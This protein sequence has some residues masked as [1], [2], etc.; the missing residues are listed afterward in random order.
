MMFHPEELQQP[1]YNQQVWGSS[2]SPFGQAGGLL[3][4]IST[5]AGSGFGLGQAAYGQPWSPMGTQ[6][7][8]QSNIGAPNMGY[9]SPFGF[10]QRQV[11][12]QDV[13]DVV[14]Q[15]VPLLPHLIA[16]AQPQ[17]AYGYGAIGSNPWAQQG[18]ALSQQDVNEVVRQI[19]P[20]VPQIANALQGQ[21]PNFAFPGQYGQS[22]IGQ[23]FAG[24]QTPFAQNPFAQNPAWH[25]GL[26]Q[27]TPFMAA[28]GGVQQRQLSQQD[29]NEIARQLVAVIPQVIGALQASQQRAI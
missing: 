25:Q 14:R 22:G 6:P 5:G 3:G 19:L 10:Q 2:N 9:G 29:V 18:R 8:G 24:P 15:L 27:Q 1:Q 26:T 4:A 7:F 17:A 13:G 21:N 28:F 12:Q 11:S 23:A 16:Q 20:L